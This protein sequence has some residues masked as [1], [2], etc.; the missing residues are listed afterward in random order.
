MRLRFRVLSMAAMVAT[1]VPVC[2]SAPGVTK[3]LDEDI[4]V[5]AAPVYEP[6]A[7]LRGEERFPQGAQLLLVH[8]GNAAPLVKGFAASA[9]ANISFDGK[10]VLFAGKQA[11]SDPWQIWELTLADGSVRRLIANSADAIRPLYLPAGQLVY[12]GRTSTGYRLVVAGKASLSMMAPVA[13]DAGETLLPISHLQGSAIPEDVLLDGRILFEANFPLG[14]GTTPELFLVYSDGSGVESYRCDHGRAR[15]GGKQLA[16][17]DVIFTHGASLARFTSP[18]AHE[19]PVVAPHAEYAGDL[20]ETA[21]GDWVVSS[22]ASSAAHYALKL[23]RPDLPNSASLAMQ[24]V[25]AVSGENLVDPV[26]VAPRTRPHHHPS[27]L[28]PWSYAN[29]LALDSRLSREGDLR[30]VP[31]SV[32]LETMDAQGRAV[33]NGTA[34]VEADGSFFVQVPGDRPIRFALLNAKGAVVRQEHGWFWI[35]SGEQRICTGC[36]TGPERASENRV[37]DVLMRTTVP[38]DLTGAK[39]VSQSQTNAPGG[40]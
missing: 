12:A 14:S 19:V 8:Q 4:V 38:L 25:F 22:R 11:A 5:T 34:P 1:L 2:G 6:L 36:H 27:A 23:A 16:S 32:R 7:V 9:D 28:H 37:P 33:A 40:N 21:Q 26:L 29:L 39:A 10:S 35:R 30:T 3:T 17:G 31:A 18:M 20:A 15:W 24:A 13:A